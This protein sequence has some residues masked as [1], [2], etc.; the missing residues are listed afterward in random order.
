MITVD[1]TTNIDKETANKLVKQ[2]IDSGGQI[3]FSGYYKY[4]FSFAGESGGI[5]VYVSFG[6][7]ADDIYREQVNDEPFSLDGDIDKLMEQ[8]CY[9][10]VRCDKQEYCVYNY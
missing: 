4:V 1:K 5:F 6:G 10:T 8:Y 3:K 2:F 7:N 9:L